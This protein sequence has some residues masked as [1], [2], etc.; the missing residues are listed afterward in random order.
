L[1]REVLGQS[2]ANQLGLRPAGTLGSLTKGYLKVAGQIEGR[3]LH[4]LS[5]LPYAICGSS[6]LERV[7][8]DVLDKAVREARRIV[9]TPPLKTSP[10]P[11]L[12]K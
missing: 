3:L 11:A 6:T 5:M 12:S 9:L 4:G 8:V 1:I 10:L 7:L 2:F